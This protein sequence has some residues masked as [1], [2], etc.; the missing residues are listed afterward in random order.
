MGPTPSADAQASSG[1]R[2]GAPGQAL[3]HCKS[4]GG[5]FPL[6]DFYHQRNGKQGYLAYRHKACYLE[7]TRAWHRREM[8]NNPE[9]RA[10]VRARW[11]AWK[12]AKQNGSRVGVD[13]AATPRVAGSTRACETSSAI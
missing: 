5:D 6:G 4:C 11:A 13:S 7:Q 12:Q 2:A 8:K 10:S 9:F 1:P 3:R